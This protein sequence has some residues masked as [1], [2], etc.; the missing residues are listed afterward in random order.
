MDDAPLFE[1]TTPTA[2]AAGRRLTTAARVRAQ[3][4]S[5]SGDDGKIEAIIDAVSGECAR[6]CRLARPANMATPPTFGQEVVKATWLATRQARG[7]RLVLPWRVAISA[8]GQVVESGV[9]LTANTDYRLIAG[10]ILERLAEDEPIAWSTGKIV[11]P[12]TAGWV[13]PDGVPAELEGLV[14]EQIKARYLGLQRDPALKATATERVGSETY[15]TIG[16][17]TGLLPALEAALDE[18]RARPV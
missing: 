8:F 11:V 4:G 12:Y 14:T 10:G 3:I 16:A 9:N 15:G 7:S 2:S 18:F 17:D 13:L 5:P 1:V 6:H